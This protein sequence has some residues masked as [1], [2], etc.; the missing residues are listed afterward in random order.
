MVILLPLAPLSVWIGTVARGA[1]E[2]FAQAGAGVLT[3]Q[4]D[5]ACVATILAGSAVP[6]VAMR[7]M[8]QR[9]APMTPHLSAALGGLAA[10]GVGNLGVC[11]FHPHSSNLI[12][13]FW[14][15]GTVLILA[16]LAGIAG[17]HVL[18]WPP[19]SRLTMAS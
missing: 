9:G 14:H 4:A 10:A 11:L 6:A 19:Q 2:E 5:W 15:C 13:L 1:L 12:L 7:L 3:W 16:A 18:R 17:H 8:L